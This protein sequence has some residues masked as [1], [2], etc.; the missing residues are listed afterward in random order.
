MNIA[1][2]KAKLR[3]IINR[4]NEFRNFQEISHPKPEF[5]RLFS[6]YNEIQKELQSIYPE[7]FMDLKTV[8]IT[9]ENKQ[10]F[11]G[12]HYNVYKKSSLEL[13][14]FEVEKALSYI[15]L[16]ESE[17]TVDSID[18][19]PLIALNII[20]ER[21]HSV[22]RQLRKRYNDRESLNVTDEYDVQ[23]LMHA[24]LKLFFN[25]IRP[26][27]YSPNYA[28]SNSRIDF[29][30]KNESLAI[31]TK[32]SRKS[33]RAKDIGEQL[34]IDI[35]RYKTYPGINTL[36]CFV[37]DPDGWIENPVGLENDLSGS[38]DSLNVIVKIEPKN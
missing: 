14:F 18:K 11:Y 28:G 38:K 23:D 6:D 20:I 36:V 30:L 29:I 10:G 19:N 35:D 9:S 17:K 33:L 22:E 15:G 16:F 27:S 32:K 26:E 7:I 31:E 4:V 24:L 21:F 13:L 3:I 5:E 12:H 37:Y 8:A 2:I 34:I 25:D 1:I